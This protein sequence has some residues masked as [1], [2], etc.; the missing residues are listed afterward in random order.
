MT[1]DLIAIGIIII[2]VGSI[3]FIIAK[4]FPVISSI[5]TTVLKK[6]Q[7]DE[8]KRQLIESRLKRKLSFVSGFYRPKKEEQAQG[9]ESFMKRAQI[10]IQKLEKKYRDNANTVQQQQNGNGDKTKKQKSLL[11]EEAKKMI[12]EERYKEAEDKYIEAISLDNQ[13]I[14]AYEGLAQL[15]VAIKDY[16]HAKETYKYLLKIV[17]TDEETNGK[18]KTHVENEKEQGSDSASLNKDIAK[19]YITLG[20]VYLLGDELS[21][22]KEH[23]EEAI[24]LEPNNPRNLDLLIQTA[25]KSR[26][27]DTVKR[28]LDKL[29]EVN[30]KNEKLELIKKELRN[31]RKQKV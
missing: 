26:D 21:E 30:P 17:T 11:L 31:L 25:L 23:F 16:K 4:K 1:L 6:H 2:S 7:Q 18:E 12:E 28:Y 3:V 29:K 14:E 27:T 22:A 5:N 8:V 15:Y 13:Y 20:E 24:K 9:K 19:Y 10:F